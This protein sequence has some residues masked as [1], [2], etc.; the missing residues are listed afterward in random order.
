MTTRLW[1]SRTEPAA[2]SATAWAEAGFDP[3]VAP[4]I[5]IEPVKASAEVPEQASFIFTSA[6]G[7]RNCPVP[8]GTRRVYAVG[9][10]TAKAAREAG[11]VNVVKGGG[12]WKSL[13]EVI[14]INV[15]PFI[16]FCGSTLQGAM[17]EA[18]LAK[19]A[20]AERRVVYR[21]I[22]V[23]DWPLDPSSVEAVAL[24]SPLAART[25]LGLPHRDLSH[26][27]AFCL[28]EAVAR[29]FLAVPDRGLNLRIAAEPTE[30]ALIACSE[31]PDV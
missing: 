26:L 15:E 16:H 20:Q 12:D 7:V 8:G 10:A 24:Y 28:S 31:T 23:S 1:L 4:L 19:G 14:E 3:V 5:T 9:P 21:N 17:V 13:I 27:S 25:L 18:L 11:F 30:S 2:R 29:P 6:H 22:G